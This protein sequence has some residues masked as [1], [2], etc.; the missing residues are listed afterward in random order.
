MRFIRRLAYWLRL[1]SHDADLMGEVIFHREMVQRD[2]VGR[3]MDPDAARAEARRTMG[4]ENP[5]ARGIAGRL[6]A[7]V[8]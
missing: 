8:P 4:N 7:A 1:S 3:G 6:A 5:H 2:L